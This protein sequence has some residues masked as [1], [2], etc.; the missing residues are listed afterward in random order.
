MARELSLTE[1]KETVKNT[2][3]DLEVFIH[4]ALCTCYSG[5]CH[6]S[7][8]VEEAETEEMCTAVQIKLQL[9]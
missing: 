3:A 1:L 5:Q 6:M 8:W 7:L 2:D 4:G 9:L